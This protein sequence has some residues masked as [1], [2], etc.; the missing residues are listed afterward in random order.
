MLEPSQRRGNK[1]GQYANS[2]IERDMAKAAEAVKAAKASKAAKAAK[3]AEAAE[4]VKGLGFK[5]KSYFKHWHTSFGVCNVKSEKLETLQ[6]IRDTEE[7]QKEKQKYKIE[8]LIM[9]DHESYESLTEFLT[10]NT[11]FSAI[12]RPPSYS[13]KFCQ[14]T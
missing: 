9:P 11:K 10:Q 7:K 12:K 14:D 2:Y 4:A 8:D 13:F 1:T 5:P 6:R 3:A